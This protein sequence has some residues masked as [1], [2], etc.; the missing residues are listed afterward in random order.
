MV[1]TFINP[2]DGKEHKTSDN[3]PLTSLSYLG[4]STPIQQPNTSNLTYNPNVGIQSFTNSSTVT[5]PPANANVSGE[6]YINETVKKAEPLNKFET[7]VNNLTDP[8]KYTEPLTPQNFNLDPNKVTS[9]LGSGPETNKKIKGDPKIVEAVANKKSD[10]TKEKQIGG[11]S[12]NVSINIVDVGKAARLNL[13]DLLALSTYVS[14]PTNLNLLAA[15]VYLLYN[16]SGAVNKT[17]SMENNPNKNDQPITIS[18]NMLMYMWTKGNSIVKGYF[19]K[20]ITKIFKKTPAFKDKFFEDIGEAGTTMLS[21]SERLPSNPVSGSS[22]HTPSLVERMLNKIHPKFSQELEKYVN[23]LKGKVYLALPSGI[24]GSIQYAI[25]YINGIVT[26]VAQQINEIYQGAL[27]A[28]RG[29]IAAI[30]SIMGMIM[31]TILSLVDKIIPLEII[32]LILDIISMF[33]GDLTFITNFFSHSAKISDVLKAFNIGDPNIANFLSDPINSLKD[34]LPDDIKNIVS[35][36]DSVAN[37]PMGYLGGVLSD[38][39]YSYMAKYLEGDIMGG[40]L[41]QF[42]SQAPI[43]YPISGIMKKYGVS[44]K[45]QLT[46]PNEPSPNV[47]LPAIITEFR[48]DVKKTF[49]GLGRST[50]K[51]Q[52]TIDQKVYD[53]GQGAS[54]TFGLGNISERSNDLG[55]GT[56]NTSG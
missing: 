29:F 42:G 40:V 48:K 47:V 32:C 4:N 50:E 28:I 8:L 41:D 7:A 6:N 24:L 38:Y 18:G 56:T 54:D 25:S 37:D 36:A 33:V 45:I 34:F 12:S 1:I 55:F 17:V 31:Q 10:A 44:G 49:D 43:L 21:N 27:K 39:G 51:L 5:V 19:H 20:G 23:V 53:I 35:I 26:A 13:D 9:G 15:W 2:D 30:D 22:K 14:G 52:N 16:G 46:D 11:S 3:N